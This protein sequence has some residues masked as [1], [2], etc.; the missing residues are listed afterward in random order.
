MQQIIALLSKKG[1]KSGYQLGRLK[2]CQ[3][4]GTTNRSTGRSCLGG[5][6][7]TSNNFYVELQRNGNVN[8][9]CFASECSKANTIIGKWISSLHAMLDDSELWQPG[10]SVDAALL[11]N[12]MQLAAKQTPKKEQIS[13]QP[14]YTQLSDRICEYLTHYFVFVTSS[15]VYVKQKLDENGK[16]CDYERFSDKQLG[17]IVRPYKAAFAIFDNSW[18]RD[19]YAT[20]ARF[21]GQPW[22]ERTKPDEYNL[23][24]G[25]MPLLSEQQR[26]LDAEELKQIQPILDHILQSLCSNNST[27]YQHLMAWFAHVMQHPELKVGWTPVLISEQGVGK[28]MILSSLLCGIFQELGLHVTN[29]SSVV[30]RYE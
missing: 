12:V 4:Y 24:A 19:Q 20:K 17:P 30:N 14:F 25:L 29:F 1:I 18:Q 16:V 11:S 27:D 7:H 5:K 28:G 22:D 21:V 6:Q 13:E 15:V 23:C 3:F 10:P 26:P 9:H 2:G 8:F